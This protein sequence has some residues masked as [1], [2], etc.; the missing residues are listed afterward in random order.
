MDSLK[1]EYDVVQAEVVN[2]INTDSSG[3]AKNFPQL[4]DDLHKLQNSWSK[5]WLITHV[6]FEK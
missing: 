3:H 2:F 6:Y 4:R 5:A 1:S